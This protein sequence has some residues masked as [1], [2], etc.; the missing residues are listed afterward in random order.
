MSRHAQ[1][2]VKEWKHRVEPFPGDIA[3]EVEVRGAAD[4][5]DAVIHLT[6]IVA[7]SPPDMTFEKV[8]VDPKNA[9]VVYVMNTSMYRSTDAGKTWSAPSMLIPLTT[10]SRENNL[11]V[12]QFNGNIYTT[13][14]PAGK[15][16]ELHLLKSI[17][18]GATWTN[19]IIYS[20]PATSCLENAFPILAVD[21]GGNVHVVFTQSTGCGPAPARTNAHVFLI[22]SGDAGATWTSSRRRSCRSCPAGSASAA[23]VPVSP[24][25]W[26]TL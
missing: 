6:A 26:W 4:G 16:Y 13:Y 24:P 8:N 17:D 22:S 23:S 19:T 5:C 15:P 1:D 20:A 3:N 10:L 25:T 12:D 2:D 14:T 9:D 18:G 21:R 11:G 7:E